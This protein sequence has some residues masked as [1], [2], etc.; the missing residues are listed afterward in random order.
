MSYSEFCDMQEATSSLR[1][2]IIK[3]LNDKTDGDNLAI[4][5]FMTKLLR[6]EAKKIKPED[7]EGDEDILT[8]L[9]TTSKMSIKL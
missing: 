2:A 4:D 9:Q 3:F 1:D 6:Q 8:T 5:E 7:F